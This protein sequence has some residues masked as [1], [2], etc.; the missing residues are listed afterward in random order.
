MN[1]QK[2]EQVLG[3]H[4]ETGK[5]FRDGEQKK[6]HKTCHLAALCT[7]V[8][9]DGSSRWHIRDRPVRLVEFGK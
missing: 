8:T 4:K 2:T 5:P 3:I 1:S 9:D 7:D 6:L